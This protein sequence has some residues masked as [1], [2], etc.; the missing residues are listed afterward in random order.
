MVPKEEGATLHTGVIESVPRPGV[1]V[2]FVAK[3]RKGNTTISRKIYYPSTS[4]LEYFDLDSCCCGKPIFDASS[5]LG[6][7][8]RRRRI[9]V[10]AQFH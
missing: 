2:N 7:A 9:D 1:F 10:A 3:D 4:T 5:S 6:G 8:R